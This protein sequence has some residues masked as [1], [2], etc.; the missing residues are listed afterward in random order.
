M[1]ADLILKYETAVEY[2]YSATEKMFGK[3]HLIDNEI[4]ADNF[5]EIDMNGRQSNI[6]TVP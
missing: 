4:S 2:F 1:L 3:K 6:L 5:E